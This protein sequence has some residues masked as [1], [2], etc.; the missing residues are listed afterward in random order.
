MDGLVEEM[1]ATEQSSASPEHDAWQPRLVMEADVLS[2]TKPRERTESAVTAVQAKH[3]DLFSAKKVQAGPTSSTSF[4]DNFTGHPAL[5][6]SRDDALVDNGAAASKS[7]LSPLKMCT[8]TAASG[9]LPART[10]SAATKT[11][12][13]QPPI[14]FCPAEEINLRTSNQYATDYSSFWKMKILQTKSMQT[15]MFDPG[16]V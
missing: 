8:P 5:P 12:L 3:G 15:L 7:C 6:C 4:G 1:K 13:D 2:D 9:L 16:G 11:T 10:A 14:L